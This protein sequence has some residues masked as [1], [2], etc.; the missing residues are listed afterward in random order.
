MRIS[1]WDRLQNHPNEL[2][3]VSRR[4]EPI[5]SCTYGELKAKIQHFRLFLRSQNIGSP[6]PCAAIVLA[7]Q[8]PD[9]YALFLACFFSNIT[10]IVV[11]VSVPRRVRLSLIKHAAETFG[12]KKILVCTSE[13]RPGDGLDPGLSEGE[14]GTAGLLEF[15]CRSM[16]SSRFESAQAIQSESSIAP[17]EE[18][19]ENQ[20]A[21]I[22]FTSGTS[23][24]SKPIM[25]SWRSVNAFA[26]SL[27][28]FH[29]LKPG[30]RVS[31]SYAPSFDPFFADLLGA[32]LQGATLVPIY[33]EDAAKLPELIKVEKIVHWSS[34]PSFAKIGLLRLSKNLGSLNDLKRTIFT[35]EPLS[36]D[37]VRNWRVLAPH[38]AIENLYGPTETTIWIARH[39]ID[40]SEPEKYGKDFPSTVPIGKLFPNHSYRL[41][42]SSELIVFGPQVCVRTDTADSLDAGAECH[43]TG[44]LVA[45][46]PDDNLCWVGRIDHQ[47][48]VRG[49]R[50]QLDVVEAKF[51]SACNCTVTIGVDSNCLELTIFTI[52]P[53]SE[54]DLL[55]GL[56]AIGDLLPP[57][58]L[59]KAAVVV[60]CLP[61]NESGK[62]IRN[63]DEI[64]RKMNLREV[65]ENTVSVFSNIKLPISILNSDFPSFVYL[66]S[67]LQ[68]KAKFL[69]EFLGAISKTGR[70]YFSVKSNPNP[71]IL[72]QL[73][74]HIDGFDVSSQNEHRQVL[75][76]VG[77]ARIT[78][79]GPAKTESWFDHLEA[80]PIEVIHLDNF[81][82]WETVQSRRVAKS[83]TLRLAL[84]GLGAQK[85]GF[86]LIQARKLLESVRNSQM[87]TLSGFH[88]YLGREN[89]SWEKLSSVLFQMKQLFD[90]YPD[91][92]KDKRAF[93]G[94]GLPSSSIAENFFFARKDDPSFFRTVEIA[95]EFPVDFEMGRA[96]V[97]SSG[98][99]V[100]TVIAVKRRLGRLIVIVNG[101]LQHLASSLSSPTY[102]A[103]EIQVAV[104][105][106]GE[107][108]IGQA[109][110]KERSEEVEF[111]GS[112]GTWSDRIL[113][114]PWHLGSIQKGDRLIF[115]PAGAYGPT[116][117]SSEFI[118][119]E[120]A[121]E[122]FYS[123]DL[124]LAEIS[125]ANFYLPLKGNRP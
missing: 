46:L 53:L 74:S 10:P 11:P 37:L 124:K 38:S 108:L 102:G 119:L 33:A 96:L 70:L 81:E 44:D 54:V 76:A 68:K 18:P 107:G 123:S 7:N 98:V 19:P 80:Q 32:V 62:R 90:F 17:P 78:A 6:Q 101:G 56:R 110:K 36:W 21:W 9:S 85:L 115:T 66:E 1:L 5:I 23:G 35:G 100:C 51:S 59:P 93:V 120:P 45:R 41:S 79:S 118:A 31:Q 87:P 3:F 48:K 13:S 99:Y 105:R 12:V 14:S 39:V 103:A 50:I 77:S 8:S 82:E 67:Q 52:K 72:R 117:A 42:E 47:V 73:A 55:L 27:L 97:H 106:P 125:N 75:A 22:L 109:E 112:L 104:W 15:D 28:Q 29:V 16:L 64:F 60:D 122:F 61:V 121:R 20:L 88:V 91:C 49:H 111:Y 24:L 92:F 94:A 113:S 69:K 25:I 30:E 71:E 95:N 65:H 40:V 4:S 116:A 114:S 86:S 83:L 2:M 63:S 89:F 58:I 26:S 84:D 43:R 57:A 34:T